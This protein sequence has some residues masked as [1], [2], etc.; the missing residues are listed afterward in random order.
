MAVP[1]DY[2][3]N[4]TVLIDELKKRLPVLPEGVEI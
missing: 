4:V 3:D 1:I 2:S